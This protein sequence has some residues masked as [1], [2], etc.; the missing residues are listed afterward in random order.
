MSVVISNSSN[1]FSIGTCLPSG[2]P[3]IIVLYHFLFFSYAYL[4]QHFLEASYRICA[5]LIN[6]GSERKTDVEIG[7]K[8]LNLTENTSQIDIFLQDSS[9]SSH[10]A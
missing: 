4:S 6:T 5:E 3:A 7:L 2:S 8:D 1:M 10:N 9:D